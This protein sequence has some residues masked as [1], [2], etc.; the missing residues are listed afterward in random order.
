M[1]SIIFLHA[2]TGLFH[3]AEVYLAQLNIFSA[4]NESQGASHHV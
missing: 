1:W 4:Q 3:L 2:L